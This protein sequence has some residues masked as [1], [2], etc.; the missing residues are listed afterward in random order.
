MDSHSRNICL[1]IGAILFLTA[2]PGCHG[3]T[4]PSEES[5]QMIPMGDNNQWT[6]AVYGLDSTGNRTGSR[7]NLTLIAY[8]YESGGRYPVYEWDSTAK[9]WLT[10]DVQNGDVFVTSDYDQWD[11]IASNGWSDNITFAPYTDGTETGVLCG[12]AYNGSLGER[13]W[14][15]LPDGHPVKPLFFSATLAL[16]YSDTIFDTAVYH[17][18]LDTTLYPISVPA[19][20]FECYK[21]VHRY[22]GQIGDLR[23]NPD[24]VITVDTIYMTPGKGIIKRI[25]TVL[26][27][28]EVN[29][30]THEWMI[31]NN[32]RTLYE[33]SSYHIQ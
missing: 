18:C 9:F 33:L 25:T 2:Q 6:Y 4:G 17:A 23:I 30:T 3:P 10:S 28:M 20:S 29:L 24:S 12:D 22:D 31:D 7:A 16:P 8:P 14:F 13:F 19:G 1:L 5:R 21:L 32:A 15:R 26:N 11:N 27:K